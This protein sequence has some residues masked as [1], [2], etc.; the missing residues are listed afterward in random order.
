MVGPLRSL[1][2]LTGLDG[3][4]DAIDSPAYTITD[5][6]EIVPRGA[7]LLW[8]FEWHVEQGTI[9]EDIAD[10]IL[11]LQLS[12]HASSPT[13][14]T[15]YAKTNAT[16]P[17]GISETPS[18]LQLSSFT[19]FSRLGGSSREVLGM[20]A[21]WAKGRDP[22]RLTAVKIRKQAGDQLASQQ[23]WFRGLSLSTL[24]LTLAFFVPVITASNRENEFGP[25]MYTTDSLEY[26]LEYLRGGGAIMV[27]KSPDLREQTVW[28]PNLADWISLV[29]KWTKIP[30]AAASQETL[31]YMSSD[32][33]MGPIRAPQAGQARRGS[34]NRNLAPRQSDDNQLVA[35][36]YR[37]LQALANSLFMIIFV[38]T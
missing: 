13:Q 14:L 22:A 1:A 4:I 33:I 36:S 25:G 16:I 34:A 8:P 28:Q 15:P 7:S 12:P 10:R 5:R 30:L 23:L 24:E 26:C 6:I 9:T 27:F 11:A 2:W 3:L 19:A 29:S 21:R 31:P 17:A 20:E 35:T 37:G 32:F 38:A 18:A